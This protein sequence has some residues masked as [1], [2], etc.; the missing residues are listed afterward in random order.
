MK[1]VEGGRK[2]ELGERLSMHR[3]SGRCKCSWR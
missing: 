1:T 3:V 2:S